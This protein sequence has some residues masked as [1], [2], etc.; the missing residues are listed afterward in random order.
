MQG[1]ND[2]LSHTISSDED[3]SLKKA[4]SDVS[5]LETDSFDGNRKKG[6]GEEGDSSL[7]AVADDHAGN[8]LVRH[9]FYKKVF[10][11]FF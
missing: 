7:S 5:F 10:L 6:G 2:V 1:Y 9:R 4:K 3:P 8:S 11:R